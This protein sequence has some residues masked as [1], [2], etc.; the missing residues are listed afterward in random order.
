[1][2]IF[3]EIWHLWQ[4]KAGRNGEDKNESHG[5]SLGI[6]WMGSHLPTQETWDQSLVREDATG[7]GVTEYVSL[8]Y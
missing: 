2:Y 1:M 5:T 6:E 3:I 8:N 4:L 7:S